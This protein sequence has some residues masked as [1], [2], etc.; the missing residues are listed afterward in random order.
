[1]EVQASRGRVRIYSLRRRGAAARRSVSAHE[2]RRVIDFSQC[3][4]HLSLSFSHAKMEVYSY[5]YV[6]D[7]PKAE[8]T[9]G[10]QGRSLSLQL[11][12]HEATTLSNGLMIENSKP[13]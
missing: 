11:A 7:K 9:E 8:K 12:R 1:M 10:N 13:L 2:Q 5:D 3:R 6:C 4:L